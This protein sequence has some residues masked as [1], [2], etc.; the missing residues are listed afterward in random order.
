MTLLEGQPYTNGVFICMTPT[1]KALREQGRTSKWFAKKCK[2]DE[3]T[4]SNIVNDKDRAFARHMRI[5]LTLSRELN[6]TVDEL[7]GHLL[8]EKT[9]GVNRD[10][11]I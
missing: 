5:A 6:M 2:T 7:W 11:S 3:G 9:N 4:M 1:K 10:E 8:D